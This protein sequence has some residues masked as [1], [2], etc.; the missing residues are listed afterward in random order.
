MVF[1]FFFSS[2]SGISFLYL[3]FRA[4]YATLATIPDGRHSIFLFILSGSHCVQR[5]PEWNRHVHRV[6]CAVWTKVRLFLNACVGR[7]CSSSSTAHR[8]YPP[9]KISVFIWRRSDHEWREKSETGRCDQMH[10]RQTNSTK[11]LF[12]FIP[13]QLTLRT[14]IADIRTAAATTT[15]FF[16]QSSQ[17]EHKEKDLPLSLSN[18]TSFTLFFVSAVVSFHLGATSG[19]A[20]PKTY[21]NHFHLNF[22]WFNLRYLIQ[23]N[24]TQN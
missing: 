13:Y 5:R 16:F 23:P 19:Q 8:V 6:P 2:S 9:D 3:F 11:I 7:N 14:T 12:E 17:F 15:F 20:L 21:K 22:K 18:E 1:F 24:T 10:A 4:V